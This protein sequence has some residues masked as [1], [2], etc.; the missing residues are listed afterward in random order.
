MSSR[1][2]WAATVLSLTFLGGVYLD[3]WAHTH[4]RV[5]ETFFT[6]W[7]AALYS[8]YL[9]TAG[10]LVGRA[11]W[12]RARG[13]SWGRM[14]PGGYLLSLLG[15]GFWVFGGPFDLAWHTGFGFEASV[16]ALMSPAHVVL[17]L[18]LGLMASGPLRAA[19]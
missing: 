17:A 15:A 19:L 12:G 3:G 5:D 10:L 1:F 14:M 18:G 7:H 8:G 11:A 13:A 6:P 16:E 2:D 4:G 9:A